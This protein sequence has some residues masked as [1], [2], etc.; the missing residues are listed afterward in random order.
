M[1]NTV[2]TWALCGVPAVAMIVAGAAAVF[3]SEKF[4][5]V[6]IPETVATTLYDPANWFAMAIML[7]MPFV[8]VVAVPIANPAKLHDGPV[9][10]DVNVTSIPGTG[11]F[12]LSLTN[13]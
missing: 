7:A 6:E 13:A 2:P 5:G 11:L 10:G 9:E 3:D 12:Q 1:E 8:S 4:A